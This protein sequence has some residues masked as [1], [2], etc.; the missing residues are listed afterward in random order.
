MKGGKRKR[1]KSDFEIDDLYLKGF[2]DE[3]SFKLDHNVLPLWNTKVLDDDIKENDVV[4]GNEDDDE[5][6][7]FIEFLT[8][9]LGDK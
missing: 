1:K 9:Y 2:C 5:M 3:K 6:K 8:K 7:E 4:I